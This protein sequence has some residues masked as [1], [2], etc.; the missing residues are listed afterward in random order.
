MINYAQIYSVEQ[1]Y[2]AMLVNAVVR[3]IRVFP[4]MNELIAVSN[5]HSINGKRKSNYYFIFSTDAMLNQSLVGPKATCPPQSNLSNDR[6]Q[7]NFGY[8]PSNDLR[9][10]S[11]I[12]SK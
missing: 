1:R 8:R 11:T 12:Y 10:C 9:Y 6:C 7:C 3:E 2:I 4:T 5:K